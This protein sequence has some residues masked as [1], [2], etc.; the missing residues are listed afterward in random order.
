MENP[1][2]GSGRVPLTG[3]ISRDL[4]RGTALESS[5]RIVATSQST[6]YGPVMIR[7]ANLHTPV[8]LSGFLEVRIQIR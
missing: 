5:I 7:I 3:G 1:T 6:V 2:R 8:R 4:N